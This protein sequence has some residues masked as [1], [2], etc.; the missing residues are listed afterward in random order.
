MNYLGDANVD[1]YLQLTFHTYVSQERFAAYEPSNRRGR[2]HTTP[3]GALA[4]FHSLI[5]H[6]P[7]CVGMPCFPFSHCIVVYAPVSNIIYEKSIFFSL[8]FILFR[9]SNIIF[10]TTEFTTITTNKHVK[11]EQYPPTFSIYKSNYNIE[12]QF[13][14]AEER[15]QARS[16]RYLRLQIPVPLRIQEIQFSWTRC[17]LA[18][19]TFSVTIILVYL[20]SECIYTN[21]S[22]TM[23]TNETKQNVRVRDNE[24]YILILN[25]LTEQY[26]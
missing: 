3:S 23:V 25:Y 11:L 5:Q 21:R 13:F 12:G 22:I 18:G 20:L 15:K 8:I 16:A 2:R 9:I 4:E 7:L 24:I 14:K 26:S 6:L 19:T 17:T 1:R 10:I